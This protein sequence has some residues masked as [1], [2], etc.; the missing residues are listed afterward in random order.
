M[1]SGGFGPNITVECGA[2]GLFV[3]VSYLLCHG[4]LLTVTILVGAVI[5]IANLK[6]IHRHSSPFK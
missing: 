3:T 1:I 6:K 2:N 5:R 4:E